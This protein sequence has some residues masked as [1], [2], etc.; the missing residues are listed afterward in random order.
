[1]ISVVIKILDLLDIEFIT[2]GLLYMALQCSTC[3]PNIE[4]DPDYH[5]HN[6]DLR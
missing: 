3:L 4:H 1:M 5:Q 6:F 2:F